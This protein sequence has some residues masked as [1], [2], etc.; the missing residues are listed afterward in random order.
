MNYPRD[1]REREREREMAYEIN[2]GN[3]LA[4]RRER[5][6]SFFFFF[7]GRRVRVISESERA[8]RDYTAA[9]AL[10]DRRKKKTAR[11]VE[12]EREETPTD[13]KNREKKGR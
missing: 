3:I 1:G 2:K 6:R 8:H 13:A 4:R 10:L 11:T 5:K 12:R 9:S 7:D